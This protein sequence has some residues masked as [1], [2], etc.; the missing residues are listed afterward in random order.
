VRPTYE[1]PADIEREREVIDAVA[2]KAGMTAHKLK[3][4]SNVDFALMKDRVVRMVCE[5][6]V[7]NKLYPQMMLS[8]DKVQAL[9]NYAAMG[10]EARVIY[11]TPEGIYVKKVGPLAIDG[12]I[13]MGGRTDRDDPDDTE[14]VVYFGQMTVNGRRISEEKDPMKRLC[15]SERR[16]FE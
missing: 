8:L 7:R 11:A 9:R 4:Y 2:S 16:W 6:K 1:T 12:W 3:A 14:M 10:L 13:G 15:D 5:V